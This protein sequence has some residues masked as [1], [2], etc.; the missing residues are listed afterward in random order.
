MAALL[1]IL[2]GRLDINEEDWQ[3]ATTIKQASNIAR[4]Q[5]VEV[6][7]ADAMKKESEYSTKLARRAVH[8]DRAVAERRIVDCSRKVA[9]KVVA[10]PERWTR[11]ELFIAMRRWRDVFDEGLDRA[12]AQGWVVE[13]VERGQGGEKR[14]LRP[15]SA[16]PS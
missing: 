7:K 9:Q 16:K 15:G 10:E 13:K 5:V 11:K 8:A 2:D 6:V 3:L 1:G 4:D 12:L 14:L